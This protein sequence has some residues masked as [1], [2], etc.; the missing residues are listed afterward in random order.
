VNRWSFQEE[1]RR[2]GGALLAFIV[3][4]CA[5]QG[6][7]GAEPGRVKCVRT[8]GP[9]EESGR[10]WCS[11]SCEPPRTAAYCNGPAGRP[12]A[13]TCT[14]GSYHGHAFALDRCDS[15]DAERLVARCADGR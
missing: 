3:V 15:L 4:G 6:T 2:L 5:G 9:T 10:V 14:A 8:G 12:V 7:P 13:C 11:A 1:T